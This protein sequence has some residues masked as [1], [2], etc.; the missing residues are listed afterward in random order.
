M[1]PLKLD[2]P[3]ADM[4]EW[5]ELEERVLNLKKKVRIALVSKIRRVTRCVYLE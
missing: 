1:R 5:K 4:T 2:T 3:E